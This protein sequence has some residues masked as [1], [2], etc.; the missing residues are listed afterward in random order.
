MKHRLILAVWLTFVWLE[1][2]GDLSWA[3]LLSGMLVAVLVVVLLGPKEPLGL[4]PRPIALV[5]FM[6]FFAQNLVIASLQVAREVLRPRP[7]LLPAV[8]A[9]R[10]SPTSRGLIAVIAA[11]ISLTPGT[12]VIDITRSGSGTTLYIHVFDLDDRAALLASVARLERLAV[13]GLAPATTDGRSHK[14]ERQP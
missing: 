12:L 5:R 6:A 8:I 13:A 9:A 3:N 4:R 2:W 10:I 1:L 14:P 7:Q 11:A